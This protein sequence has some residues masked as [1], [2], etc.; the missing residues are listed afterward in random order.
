VKRYFCFHLHVGRV[1]DG[2]LGGLCARSEVIGDGA[3]LFGGE[4]HR[5]ESVCTG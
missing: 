5:G 3:L 1:A 4:G 2:A